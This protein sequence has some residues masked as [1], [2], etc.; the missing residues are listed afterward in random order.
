L[1]KSLPEARK[2]EEEE[3]VKAA[4]KQFS[5]TK[6]QIKHILSLQKDRLYEALCTQR[7]WIF[8]DWDTFL[9]HHPVVSHYC[10]SLIWACFENDQFKYSFRAL[11]DGSLTDCQDHPVQIASGSTIRLA[12][13]TYLPTEELQKWGEQ[14]SD[15]RLFPPF[16]QIHRPAFTLPSERTTDTQWEEFEGYLVEAF[17]LRG[18]ALKF[19]YTRGQ[20]GDGG[21]FHTYVKTFPTLELHIVIEFSGNPLP[22]ENRTVALTQFHFTKTVNTVQ[23]SSIQ[24]RPLPLSKIPPILLSEVWNDVCMI[25]AQGTG[26][27]PEWRKKVY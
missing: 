3:I 24:S 18:M 27:D 11:G 16:D 10:K 6:K 15:Y 12:H 5:D 2:D 21:W 20:T 13:A 1:I 22:E 8:Q 17:K 25:A 7:A 26:F 4:K 14:L 9:H 23:Q 19:G